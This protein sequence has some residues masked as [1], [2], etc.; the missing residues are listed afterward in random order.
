MNGNEGGYGGGK[1]KLHCVLFSFPEFLF[2]PHLQ[3]SSWEQLPAEAALRSQVE[4]VGPC[5]LVPA[6]SRYGCQCCL[7]TPV[8]PGHLLSPGLRGGRILWS[9]GNLSSSKVLWVGRLFNTVFIV[10][11]PHSSK[12]STTALGLGL[13]SSSP[14]SSLSLLTKVPGSPLPC[15]LSRVAALPLGKS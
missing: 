12:K 3:E 11:P 10:P 1:R 9:P 8:P 13:C 2:L 5:A 6:R 7:R 15:L 14:P 4:D